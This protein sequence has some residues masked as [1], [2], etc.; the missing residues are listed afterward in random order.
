MPARKTTS[1]TTP[2]RK[3]LTPGLKPS[4]AKPKAKPKRPVRSVAKKTVKKTASKPRV[5]KRSA[6][7]KVDMPLGSEVGTTPKNYVSRSLRK[8][9]T[10]IP[11]VTVGDFYTFHQ[12]ILHLRLLAGA[13]GL[14]RRISEGAVNRP[15]LAL[16]GFYKSFAAQRVQIIGSGETAY[17][18]SLPEKTSRQ[19]LRELFT[20]NIPCIIF[21]RN[22]NPPKVVLEEAEESGIAVFKS[23]MTTMRLLNTTTICLELDF[24]PMVTEYG[25]MIDIQGIGVMIRGPSG[26]GKSEV[27]LSLIERGHSLVSDDITKIRSLEGRELIGTSADLSRF[28]MEVRGLG[29]INVASIFG[30]RSIRY[31]KRLDLVVTLRDWHDVSEV[32][33]IGLEEEFYEILQIKVP[34]VTIPVRQGRNLASLVEVA[35]LDQK[36]KSMG[37]NS[38][39]E[40]NERLIQVIRSK[41]S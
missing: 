8:N 9:K 7:K 34:H 22:I 1:R 31:E 12:N 5:S 25:S 19:R 20:F 37:Q 36:L 24:A 17:L 28:H 2:V 14:K 6:A 16:S 21:A 26:I 18:K 29:I 15:G 39:A 13:A 30:V 10:S 33:R 27:V 35:A 40:F 4:A 11:T 32:D 38:A 41:E 3:T 23:P